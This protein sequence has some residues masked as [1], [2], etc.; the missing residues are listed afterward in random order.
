MSN[1]VTVK[2]GELEVRT[3]RLT[4]AILKQI[5]LLSFDQFKGYVRP[6]G[7]EKPEAVVGWV[8][9]SVL[10]KDFETLVIIKT[11]EGTYGMFKGMSNHR[12]K[13]PQIFVV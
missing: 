12:V 5:P 4:K 7:N 11:G 3:A 10:G 6:D 8:H 13:Y 2:V 9:G 1:S